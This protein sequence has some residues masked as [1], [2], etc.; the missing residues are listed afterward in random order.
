MTRKLNANF[1]LP[2]VLLSQI[3]KYCKTLTSDIW[4]L[5]NFGDT[6]WILAKS[7]IIAVCHFFNPFID[8][9]PNRS[10]DK[11]EYLLSAEIVSIPFH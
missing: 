10:S 3:E 1:T 9:Q 5:L 4:Q 6:G 7:A 2:V 11:K 8:T